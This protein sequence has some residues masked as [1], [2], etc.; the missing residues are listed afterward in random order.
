MATDKTPVWG[1]EGFPLSPGF[2]ELIATQVVEDALVLTHEA[3][4]A[5]RYERVAHVLALVSTGAVARV[6][7]YSA[8]SVLALSQSASPTYTEAIEQGMSLDNIVD[9][10]NIV[11]DRQPC[12]NILTLT[13]TVFS[14]SSSAPIEH[15]LGLTDEA[16][17]VG[18]HKRTVNQWLAIS[19]HIST[20]HRRFVEDTLAFVQFLPTPLTGN[21]SDILA[22]VD[23][24][25]ITNI[26]HELLLTH[27]ASGS[28]LYEFEQTLNLT[29]SNILTSDWVRR[30][31]EDLGVGHALTW[32]RDDPC[33]RK[34]YT[35]FSGDNTVNTVFE[36]PP[37][38]KPPVFTSNTEDRLV[39]YYP[40]HAA[41]A[42]QLTLRAPEFQDRDRNAYTRVS[43]ETRGGTL[44]VYSDPVWPSV[45]SLVVTVTGLTSDEAESYLTFMYAT[46]G[47]EIEVRDWE[48]RLWA[49]VIVNP[50]NPI[51]QDGPGCKYTI[52][53]ELEG[54][55]FE[56]GNPTEEADLA[57]FVLNL[58]DSATVVKVS[59]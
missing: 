43:R 19:D 2:Y 42:R 21:A 16:I 37:T 31:D 25:S 51:T 49:G 57:G 30:I 36:E 6:K 8:S 45:R 15:V 35:P 29:H 46:L 55:K 3:R 17:G 44:I 28:K 58:S 50:D 26:A 38:T 23:E 40:S 32:F 59:P 24:A 5:E 52:S 53:F 12:G 18:P 13:Q 1:D 20:P 33:D 27:V 11:G 56:T 34:N 54:K 4:T 48:G 41:I 10:F 39:L 14:I 9:G 47:K 7:S 22:L